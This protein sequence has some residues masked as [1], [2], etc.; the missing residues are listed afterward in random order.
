MIL[1][2]YNNINNSN[3]SNISNN[4]NKS[5]AAPGAVADGP[6]ERVADVDALLGLRP[7]AHHVNVLMYL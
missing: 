4:S 5:G 2:L 7:G 3:N 1:E 6:R